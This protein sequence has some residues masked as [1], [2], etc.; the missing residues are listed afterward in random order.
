MP[1]QNTDCR[2]PHGEGLIF[3]KKLVRKKKRWKGHL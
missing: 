1:Q 2:E 3:N